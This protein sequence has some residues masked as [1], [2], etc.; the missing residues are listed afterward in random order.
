MARPIDNLPPVHPGEF[1]GDELKALGTSA[2]DFARH[3]GLSHHNN[4]TDII[5]GKRGI[6]A[7]MALRLGRA[8][9]TTPE[10]WLNLQSIYE[11]KLAK[12]ELPADALKFESYATA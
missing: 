12:A 8:F 1:L 5:R 10:Y 9:G 3:I 2:R 4:I 11:L 7:T 6:S